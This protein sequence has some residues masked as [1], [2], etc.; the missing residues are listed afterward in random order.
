MSRLVVLLVGAAHALS[1]QSLLQRSPLRSLREEELTAGLTVTPTL[2][3]GDWE[4]QQA[5]R[6][7][8]NE[9]FAAGLYPGVDYRIEAR[10]E[11]ASGVQ[12]QLRPIYPLI[13]KLEREWPVVVPPALAPSWLSPG[14]YNVLVAGFALVLASGGLL[15]GLLLASTLTLSVVP[16][17]SMVPTVLPG[18]VLLVEKVSPRFGV[19]P[20]SG[21]L[22]YFRPPARLQAIAAER[23]DGSAAASALRP[24]YLKRV[25]ATA[26]ERVS[27]GARGETRVDG[28]P[29]NAAVGLDGPLAA[30]VQPLDEV[31][32]PARSFFVLG[33]NSAGSVD[34]RCWGVLTQDELV[35]RPLM[36]VFPPSRLGAIE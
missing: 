23:G 25:A 1:P 17:T 21:D 2:A 33:D 15:A 31:R 5:F 13:A 26:G 4:N 18:D 12:L 6:E 3:R 11:T 20:S 19:A 34:S 8:R 36:R 27:V 29:V 22:V 7:A 28:A 30:L 9:M 14:G 10:K 32:L 16:S 35:G 24:L